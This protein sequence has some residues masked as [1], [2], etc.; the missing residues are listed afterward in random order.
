LEQAVNYI[1]SEGLDNLFNQLDELRKTF[2]RM[3]HTEEGPEPT[4]AE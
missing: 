4:A 3:I 2:A 1:P